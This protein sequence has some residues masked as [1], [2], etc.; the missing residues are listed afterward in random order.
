MTP[1]PR[2]PQSGHM[3]TATLT[4]TPAQTALLGDAVRLE[5]PSEAQ[6]EALIMLD[7]RPRTM[8]TDKPQEN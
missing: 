7:F 4:F 3:T 8:L 1:V 6:I 2:M 5:N